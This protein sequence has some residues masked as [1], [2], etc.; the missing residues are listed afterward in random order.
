[1]TDAVTT[2]VPT[3]T[4]YDWQ[5]GAS[6]AGSLVWVFI[7]AYLTFLLCLAAYGWWSTKQ[8]GLTTVEEHI[9]DHF[10]AG[11][12]FNF[13]V[14]SLT[15]FSTVYSG[16][17]VVGVP[18]E[19]FN[20]GFNAFRWIMT[21]P[22]MAYTIALFGGRLQWLS[23]IR[24]YVSPT[25]FIK[26]RYN[27]HVLTLCVSGGLAFP[28]LTYVLAQFKSMG[29][30]IEGLSNGDIP[31]FAAAAV[32]CVIMILYETFG[33][34]RAIAWTDTLQGAVLA[35]G[36][37]M[38]YGAQE[39]LFGGVKAAGNYIRTIDT[40]T[41]D[42]GNMLERAQIDSFFG[43][44]AALF[45]SYC[46]YP[47]MIQ[48]YQSAESN[49]TFR[50]SMIALIFGSWLAV[51]CSLCTGMVALAYFET[52]NPEVAGSG[53]FGSI[54]RVTMNEGT[55]WNIIGSAM[56]TASLAAFMSTA[57]SSINGFSCCLTL[58]WFKPYAW[59]W[60]PWA[61]ADAA[62]DGNQ[63]LY[64]GKALSITCAVVALLLSNTD[65]ELSPL[66]TM[67]G[68]ILCQ[69][70]PVFF[71]G[72]FFD[73]LHP[74]SATAGF[75]VGFLISICAQCVGVDQCI[76]AGST[77]YWGGLHPGLV[78]CAINAVIFVVGSQLESMFGSQQMEMDMLKPKHDFPKKLIGWTLEGEGKRPW[79]WP[80]M[81][82]PLSGLCLAC[83]NI[84]WY[85]FADYGKPEEFVD[86]LPQY[87]RAGFVFAALN[88]MIALVSL[89]FF[90]EGGEPVAM[91][92]VGLSEEDAEK[93]GVQVTAD[94]EVGGAEMAKRDPAEP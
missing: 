8:K 87:I 67:Q 3:T 84:P 48:R 69:V 18:E 34:L 14:L 58:D 6:S 81:L 89:I 4:E 53:A 25:D 63:I 70:F 55:G 59:F 66:L 1:M 37:L 60:K 91:D 2:D 88:G 44:G 73:G 56:M 75:L 31:A 77:W 50:I 82:L 19:V 16:Y 80:Y 20:T 85:R 52:G 26:D 39:E 5:E 61:G 12:G 41:Y 90:W 86:G 65:M 54:M 62:W 45:F 10:V 94:D 33:G 11:R 35:F 32:F 23:V 30:T 27:S 51:T 76:Q 93:D 42:N 17:T 92:T 68:A 57:D 36:F 46:F 24:N 74:T 78:A 79:H 49:N 13:I 47:Q 29:S 43:F 71:G 28:A 38:F 15:V 22:V 64:I 21:I 9:T 7:S 40:M 83:F 72:C